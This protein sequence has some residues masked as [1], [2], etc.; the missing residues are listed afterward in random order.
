MQ[1]DLR[2]PVLAATASLAL[3][4]PAAAQV[5]FDGFVDTYYTYDS[6]DPAGRQRAYA[7]QTAR[8]NEFAVQYAFLRG[9][10]AGE[11]VRGA[12]NIGTGTYVEANYAAEPE[13]LK[14]IQEAYVGVEVADGFW[15][16]AGTFFS[17]IMAESPMSSLNH[18]YTR[19]LMAEYTP[20]YESGVRFTYAASDRLT[21]SALVLNGWQNIRETN[22]DKAFGTQVTFKPAPATTL[23]WSTFVGNEAPQ[24]EESQTRIYNDFYVVQDFGALDVIAAFDIGLQRDPAADE[25]KTWTT[26]ALTGRYSF[27]PNVAVNARAEYLSDPDNRI[28]GFAGDVSDETAAGGFKVGGVSVGLDLAPMPNVLFRLEARGL[29]SFNDEGRVFPTTRNDSGFRS[30]NGT[31]TAGMAITF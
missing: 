31:L 19:T 24:G 13:I 7:T 29:Q 21:L 4:A 28:V 26:G 22:G 20:Y 14:N 18:T 6:N 27:S 3:A 11:R 16:D 30:T 12:F 23:N 8:H 15:I 10:Y 2:L 1:R 9:T 25:Y 5:T 17:H